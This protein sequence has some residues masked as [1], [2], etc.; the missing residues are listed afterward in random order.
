MTVPP[1]PDNVDDF[2]NTPRHC[3]AYLSWVEE[4]LGIIPD[5]G[6]EAF[7][8]EAPEDLTHRNG[9]HARIGLS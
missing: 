6:H 5:Q 7:A 8:G 2:L 9:P 4:G 3:H 1:S